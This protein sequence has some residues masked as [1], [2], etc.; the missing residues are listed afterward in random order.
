MAVDAEG[1]WVPAQYPKDMENVDLRRLVAV[2]P[3]GVKGKTAAKRKRVEEEEEP[4]QQPE[5]MQEDDKPAAE[6]TGKRQKADDKTWR[7]VSGKVWKAPGQRASTVMKP[8]LTGKKSW[9]KRMTEKAAKQHLQSAKKEAV[10]AA[11]AKRKAAGDQRKAARERKLENQK[12]SAVV[13]K[14]TNSATV[15]KMMKDK[16][17]RKLLRTADTN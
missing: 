6:P 13:Q 11:K 5:A 12:K 9:S 7:P 4:E 17:Q 10:D 16:K 2:A 3:K 8:Q 1:E 15:K 14:I